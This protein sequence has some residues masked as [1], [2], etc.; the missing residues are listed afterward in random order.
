MASPH[1][2]GAVALLWAA[3]PSYLGN[4]GSTEQLLQDS[5]VK[6]STTQTC[7]GIPQGAV[8]NNTFGYG[9]LDVKRAVDQAGGTPNRSPVVTITTPANGSSFDCN[10]HVTFIAMATDPDGD[11]V[12]ISWKDNGSVLGT[13]SPVYK[14]YACSEAGNHNIVASGTDGRGG[15]DSDTITI[16]IVNPG[17]PAAPSNLTAT[18]SGRT[19]NLA[20]TDNSDNETGFRLERKLSTARNWGIVTSSIPA[21]STN[22]ADNSIKKPGQYQYRLFAMNGTLKSDSSNIVSVRVN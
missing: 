6:I 12:T 1:S 5:A 14:T 17:I 4:I 15:S 16:A 20:W 8:P 2:A 9:R 18:A 3:R 22:Y 19:V 7:G 21:N 13:G 10:T 11:A